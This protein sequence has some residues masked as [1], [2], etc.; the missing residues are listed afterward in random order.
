MRRVFLRSTNHS[1]FRVFVDG[2]D[3]GRLGRDGA[4]AAQV[5]CFVASIAAGAAEHDDIVFCKSERES[6]GARE[7]ERVGEREIDAKRRIPTM[8]Q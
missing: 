5:S 6:R 1:P 7:S 4:V 2:Y 3:S 8:P